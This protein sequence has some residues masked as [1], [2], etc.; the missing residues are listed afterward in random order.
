MEERSYVER[1]RRVFLN[2]SALEAD[3][4]F[5]STLAQ[6]A[7]TGLQWG[8]L[9]GIVG[10]AV[11]ILVNGGLFGRPFTWWYPSP[12][13]TQPFVLWDKTA[14]LAVCG[15]AIVL[16]RAGCRLS[17]GRTVGAA[18]ALLIAT[19]SLVH[20]T[21][22][23][24]LSIEYLILVY[25]LIVTVVPYRPWQALLLGGAMTALLYG[26]GHYGVPGT[27]A[28]R[29]DLVTPGHLV[30]MG[31]TT[32]VLTGVAALLL[33]VRYQQHRARRTA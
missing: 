26:L 29:P 23:G 24:L 1:A 33:S 17:V 18:L 5:A 30:R 6:L 8:G 9:V 25:L 3:D 31:F 20:D 28:A 11:L 16:G 19:V 7:G 14:V 12:N 15:S 21:Y 10:V 4:A 22:R 27:A 32:I 13:A 2:P